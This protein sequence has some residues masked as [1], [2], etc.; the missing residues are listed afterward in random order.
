M[1]PALEERV[2]TLEADNANFKKWQESHDISI[3]GI[4]NSIKE[5]DDKF[6]KKFDRIM[7]WN[8]TQ[9]ALLVVTFIT[10]LVKVH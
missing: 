10:I 5:T 7:F 9:L 4:R 3:Q 6:D 8:M 2:A 1:V